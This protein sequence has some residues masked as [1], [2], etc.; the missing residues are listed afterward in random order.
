MTIISQDGSMV[1]NYTNL[2]KVIIYKT[3]EGWIVDADGDTIGDYNTEAAARD[4]LAGLVR[5]L[6]LDGKTA[7]SGVYAFPADMEV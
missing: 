2:A 1:F 4:A 3:Q 5:A 7:G 6:R